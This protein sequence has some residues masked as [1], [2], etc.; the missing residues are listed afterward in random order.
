MITTFHW[1]ELFKI[2]QLPFTFDYEKNTN[3]C[4]NLGNLIVS[5]LILTLKLRYESHVTTYRHS[6]Y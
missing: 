3:R 4:L 1:R 5:P 2:I 6:L